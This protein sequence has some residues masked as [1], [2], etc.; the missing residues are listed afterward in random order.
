[1]KKRTLFVAAG[2]LLSLASCRTNKA[3]SHTIYTSFYPIY[4]FTK[5]IV[6]DK[7]KVVNITPAG[8]EPH[9]YEPKAKD[10]DEM[11]D[12]A[13]IFTNGLG[14]ET[15]TGSLPKAINEKIHVVSTGIETNKIN[16]IV[17]PHIWLS[18]P[19]AIKEMGN[20]LKEMKGIDKDNATYFQSNY[21]KAV[22]EFEKLHTEYKTTL[23][24]V[25]NKY[26]V[27]S[28]AAFGYLC[29]E[30]GLTQIYVSGLTPDDEPTPKAMEDI[31]KKVGEYNITTIFYEELVS[32]EISKKIAEEAHVK[33]QTLNPLEGLTEE[34]LKTEDYLSVMRDNLKR[35]E[36]ANR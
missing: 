26:L 20:I 22:K 2:L 17:D 33:T 9:D 24:G 1:M 35:I 23:A 16:G 29:Q 4:D 30:Y 36:E 6:G 11:K 34:E 14:L 12:G 13:A 3:T 27:V 15:W 28:H 25:K 32:P 18:V 8:S 19:N 21:D 7:Y 5:R 31:I 10:V